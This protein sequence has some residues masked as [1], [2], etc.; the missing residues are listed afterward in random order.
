MKN[1]RKGTQKKKKRLGNADLIE[2]IQLRNPQFEFSSRF[3]FVTLQSFRLHL[4]KN[5]L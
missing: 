3:C 5:L 4:I 1:Q 2:F